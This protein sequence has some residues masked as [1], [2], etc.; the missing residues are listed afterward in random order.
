MK[1]ARVV[2]V[3]AFASLPLVFAISADAQRGRGHRPAHAHAKDAGAA[4]HLE[5]GRDGGV[6]VTEGVRANPDGGVLEAKTL[7]GGTRVFRFGELDVEGRLTS[8]QNRLLPATRARRVRRRRPR[9]PKLHGR[10]LGNPQVQRFL[11]PKAGGRGVVYRTMAT[12]AAAVQTKT[13]LR[14]A[15][16]WGTTV[17]ALRSL[18]TGESFELGD[19]PE[20]VLPVPDGLDMSRAPIRA[21][22]GAWE[23]D[24]R[25]AVAG[26]LKLRGRDEDVA[27]FARAGA[28]F[29]IVPGDFGLLQY[30]QFGISS[31]TRRPLSR[32]ET[33]GRPSSSSRSRSSR[34]A[35]STSAS[36]VSCARS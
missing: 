19:E 9:S 18:E 29:P 28:P 31:S 21:A 26:V 22:Q 17:V 25:G 13:V 30:G 10:A 12:A 35:C 24:A 6:A 23:I 14:V 11:T 32:S 34:A 20:S 27:S 3:L 33:T 16:V 15:A 7:D 1:L 8:P 36:S 5:V 4:H 2:F